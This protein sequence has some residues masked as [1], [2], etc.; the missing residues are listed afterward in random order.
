M[1]YKERQYCLANTPSGSDLYIE[2]LLNTLVDEE[3]EEVKKC[4]DYLKEIT[5]S[6]SYGVEIKEMS[7]SGRC[8]YVITL[9]NSKGW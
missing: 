9:N 4:L 8:D 7:Y 3:V 1:T 5:G 2:H 6:T